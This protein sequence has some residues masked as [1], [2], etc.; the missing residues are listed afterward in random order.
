MHLLLSTSFPIWKPPEEFQIQ[1]FRL[2][3]EILDKIFHIYMND[4]GG[5][6]KFEYFQT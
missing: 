6:G 5:G 1:I 3:E 4:W 2:E